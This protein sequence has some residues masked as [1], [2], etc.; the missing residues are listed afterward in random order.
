MHTY[1]VPFCHGRDRH[2][3][4]SKNRP[5]FFCIKENFLPRWMVSFEKFKIF[6]PLPTSRNSAL[7]TSSKQLTKLLFISC[8]FIWRCTIVL[9]GY[10]YVLGQVTFVASWIVHRDT[11]L[12]NISF[13]AVSVTKENSV[14]HSHNPFVRAIFPWILASTRTTWTIAKLFKA[15]CSYC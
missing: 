15:F 6:P 1:G 4:S 5:F 9:V 10:L 7:P 13:Q 14:T 11:I 8:I 2:I 12:R 3:A